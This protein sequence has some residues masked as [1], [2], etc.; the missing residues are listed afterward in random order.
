MTEDSHQLLRRMY[1]AFNE[2]DLIVLAALHPD[3]DWPNG[4]EGGWLRG[5]EAVHAYWLRQFADIDPTVEPVTF[6]DVGS[7]TTVVTVHQVVR[8]R[9][10]AVVSDTVVTHTYEI[11]SGLVR[12]MTIG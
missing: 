8:D 12:R 10:G 3:V 2:R 7:G 6:S 11:V 5:R 1:R 4:W 9:S